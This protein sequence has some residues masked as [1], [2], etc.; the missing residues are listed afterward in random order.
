[1]KAVWDLVVV[2]AGPAGSQAARTAA[3]RGLRVLLLDKEEFPRP[4]T[5]GGLISAKACTA[6]GLALPAELPE[7]RIEKVVFWGPDGATPVAR[8]APFLGWTVQRAAFDA[9]LVEEAVQSGAEFQPGTTFLG[10]EKVTDRHISLRTNRGELTARAVIGADGHASTVARALRRGHH[11]PPWRTGFALAAGLPLPGARLDEIFHGQ[12]VHFYCLPLPYALGWAFP[13][14]ES[15]NLGIGTWSGAAALLPQVFAGFARQLQLTWG[16]PPQTLKPRGARLPAG[17]LCFYP[18][19]GPVLLAGEA[20]GL[21]DPFAG[22]GIYYALRSGQLAAETAAGCLAAAPTRGP[23]A[24]RLYAG[25]CRREL[26]SELRPALVHTLWAGTKA[27]FFR[28]LR[29]QPERLEFIV[30]IMTDP[31]AY[32]T[33][34]PWGCGLLVGKEPAGRGGRSPEHV[35]GE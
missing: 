14:R 13:Y 27:R 24:A 12:A 31:R 33:A 21:V 18:G 1:M 29:A 22:E 5:C 23:S 17:G 30:R 15:V 8:A 10:I 9:F 34:L 32:R 16:L 20:A 26:L 35:K 4:K 6:L 25:A 2:G 28:R 19:R 3:A 11:W 7:R